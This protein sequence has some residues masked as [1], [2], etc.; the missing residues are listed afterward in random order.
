MQHHMRT[1][2]DVAEIEAELSR[3]RD[4]LASALGSLRQSLTAEALLG[5]ASSMIKRNASG[6]ALAVD[7]AVKAN[8]A[9]VALTGV[10]LAWLIL[11][12]R[13]KAPEIDPSTLSGTKFEA[14]S[15]W[16]DEGGPAFDPVDPN[17]DW[18][19]AA[20]ALRDRA[21][22]MIAKIDRAARYGLASAA[23]LAASRAEVV[24]S[25]TKDVRRVMGKGLESLS[26]QARGAAIA[27]REA[28]YN[29]RLSNVP[30]A[31]MKSVRHY[32]L[33]T[34]VA[35]A[36]AG[37]TL[38]ALFPSTRTENRLFGSARKRVVDEL[39]GVAA[40]EAER[41]STVASNLMDKL[42]ADLGRAQG[43]VGEAAEQVGNL[44]SD[45]NGSPTPAL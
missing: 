24:A 32:P 29:A 16:E 2:D 11:G 1:G 8:P 39:R 42:K 45:R 18:I 43:H 20:D 19:D 41:V 9:A 34:G 38:A 35:I 5:S 13:D 21:A 27:A 12:K 33:A 10:G 15:R 30:D 22:Q 36:V 3:D 25:L 31:T 23:D 37:A 28:T 6:Y 26:E 14:V 44:G 17:D 7:A 40:D 4:A